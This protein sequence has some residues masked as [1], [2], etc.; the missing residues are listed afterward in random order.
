MTDLLT[1]DEAA[2]LL[3]ISPWTVAAMTRDGRLP[4]IASVRR[5]RIPRRAVERMM[6]GY[7]AGDGQSDGQASTQAPAPRR[8][9]R[10]P[11]PG[12]L[13]GASVGGGGAV[14]RRVGPSEGD[15]AVRRIT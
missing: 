6:E 5:I 11:A 12:P 7:D 3:R 8:G 2:A 14:P 4:R 1:V 15:V 10:H 13:A 9:H